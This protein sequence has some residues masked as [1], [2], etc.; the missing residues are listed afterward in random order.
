VTLNPQTLHPQ[1]EYGGDFPWPQPAELA[2]LLREKSTSSLFEKGVFFG[3]GRA[4]IVALL[5]HGKATRGWRRLWVPSYF[6]PRVVET[7]E[8]A[9]W[10][11]PRYADTPI[12]QPHG[13]PVAL[14]A[15]DVVLRMNFFG[16]RGAD[17][18]SETTTLNCDVIE[19]H[20][21]DPFGPWATGSRAAFC[22]VSLR[23]T[24]PIPDGGW[25]WSP[26]QQCLPQPLEASELH[27]KSVGYKIAGMT[28]KQH[29]RAGLPIGKSTFRELL[30]NGEAL[31][32]TGE[33]QGMHPLSKSLL[34]SICPLTLGRRRRENYE[35]LIN[36]YPS[37]RRYTPV[38]HLPPEQTPF[39]VVLLF[40]SHADRELVRTK[41]ILRQIYPSLLWSLRHLTD[42]QTSDFGDRSLTLQCHFQYTESDL[43]KVA[44]SVY[45]I[46]RKHENHSS[47]K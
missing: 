5:E 34:E 2:P 39:A 36:S 25:L 19:D 10:N 7:I 14:E 31:L 26:T 13:L 42:P 38:T 47:V 28:L 11:C 17:A 18:I 16:W 12:S 3:T 27:L 9:G 41:L 24:L 35:L 20:S 6:C 15:G 43:S 22:V 40:A 33:P 46:I 21:H 45:A 30:T 4:A 32:G 1:W 8:N 23:K 37:L 44:Q 29:Y